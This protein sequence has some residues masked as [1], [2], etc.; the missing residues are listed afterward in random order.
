MNAFLWTWPRQLLPFLF[1]PGRLSQ[2]S[3]TRVL[4]VVLSSALLGSIL[5]GT[6][7]AQTRYKIIHLPTPEGYNSTAL[8]LND[9]GNVV[10]YTYQEDSSN[11]FLYHYS[12]GTT[13]DIGSLGGEATAATA[14]NG[15][16]QVVGYST[17]ANGNILAFLYTV[18][19]GSISL[20]ALPNGSHSEAFAINGSG[21]AV[22][23][24]QT[25]G[26]AHRPV[27]F[28]NK[29]VEDLG[30]STKDSDTLKTA[31]GVNA[32]GQIAGRYDTEDGSTHAFLFSANRLTDLGTLGGRDSE[33][34]GI[35]QTGAIAG[36]SETGNGTTHAFV[37]KGNSMQDLGVLSSFAKSSYARSINDKGQVVGES[38]SDTQ[39]RAFVFSDRQ[40]FDLTRAAVN[41][42]DAG[43]A[44]LDV[45][46]GIN[47]QGWI[48]GFGTTID[49]HLAGFLA[50]PVGVTADPP[51]GPDAP[52]FDSGDIGGFVWAGGGW[53]CPPT[54][55]P[56]PW[57]HFHR[58][59]TPPRRFPTP[60]RTPRPPRGFPPPRP[61]PNPPIPPFP[62]PRPTPTPVTAVP[63]PRPTPT[64]TPI[65]ILPRVRPTPNLNPNPTPNLQVRNRETSPSTRHLHHPQ[66]GEKRIAHHEPRPAV[67]HRRV[68]RNEPKPSP[69]P[70]PK[71]EHRSAST[72]FHADDLPAIVCKDAHSGRQMT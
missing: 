37:F 1:P 31:Y 41:M 19:Q 25:D 30:I 54:L 4:S 2:R 57:H 63:P 40:M 32:S 12:D 62:P 6:G 48:I 16:N 49:G 47:N 59:P 34:L 7:H 56:P 70:H 29:G 71:G 27:L 67:E 33:A 26:D 58:W 52:V 66:E 38:D 5:T 50:I 43:F 72:G 53:F 45:A 24:S 21:Q 61:T 60:P 22:G 42:R 15:S 35:N 11:A 28:T 3:P 68:T 46:D 44:A 20:G 17:D 69:R 9:S 23:D 10:G 13:Q 55:W 14:I 51:G 39:K 8:G 64:P 65:P 36:D 18:G